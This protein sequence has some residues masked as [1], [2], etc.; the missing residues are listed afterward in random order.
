MPSTSALLRAIPSQPLPIEVELL[1]LEQCQALATRMAFTATH[2]L[3]RTYGAPLALRLQ[4]SAI[5][6]GSNAALKSFLAFLSCPGSDSAQ[7]TRRLQAIQALDITL[8]SCDPTTALELAAAICRM[9]KL[10]ALTRRDPEDAFTTHG[11]LAA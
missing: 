3:L 10:E 2:Q 8:S 7:S 9:P 4:T 1:I 6:L 5:F 11:V